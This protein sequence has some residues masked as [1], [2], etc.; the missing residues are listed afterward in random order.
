MQTFPLLKLGFGFALFWIKETKMN[1]SRRTIVNITQK[2]E[3]Q[4]RE[5][6]REETNFG[7]EEIDRR[8]MISKQK[9]R[10]SGFFI[11]NKTQKEQIS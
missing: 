7:D 11:C 4:K 2:I 3:E 1:N 10:D 5:T 8:L 6:Y 9:D